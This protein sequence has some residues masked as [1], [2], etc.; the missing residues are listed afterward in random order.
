MPGLSCRSLIW[1]WEIQQKTASEKNQE[2]PEIFLGA[3][4]ASFG[5]GREYLPLPLP[6]HRAFV[7]SLL[8]H[9][10]R[11]WLLVP[12]GLAALWMCLWT[13]GGTFRGVI[14]HA[15][16]F[17]APPKSKTIAEGGSIAARLGFREPKSRESRL[18]AALTPTTGMPRAGGG[19]GR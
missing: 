18:P 5:P 3:S 15:V 4:E 11:D 13:R 8:R 16:H 19:Y 14:P 12:C 2:P 17:C 10:H 9:G 1:D 7:L 6:G